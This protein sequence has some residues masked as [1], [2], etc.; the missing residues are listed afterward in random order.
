MWSFLFEGGRSGMGIPMEVYKEDKDHVCICII[1]L[2]YEC[3]C[4]HEIYH[5]DLPFCSQF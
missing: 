3:V 4:M 5:S 2:C 1:Q